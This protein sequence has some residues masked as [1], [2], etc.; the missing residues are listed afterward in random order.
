MEE[1]VRSRKKLFG[2]PVIKSIVIWLAVF[3]LILAFISGNWQAD[4]RN[5]RNIF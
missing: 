1:L 3:A 5:Y 4:L 2:F